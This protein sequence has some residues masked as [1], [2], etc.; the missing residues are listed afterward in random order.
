MCKKPISDGKPLKV[1]QHSNFDNVKTLTFYVHSSMYKSEQALMQE[2]EYFGGTW[3]LFM[4]F[5]FMCF[6]LA[7]FSNNLLQTSIHHHSCAMKAF[8]QNVRAAKI[9]RKFYQKDLWAFEGCCVVSDDILD[10]QSTS[11]HHS[12]KQ[13]LWRQD[14]VFSK[15]HQKTHVGLKCPPYIKIDKTL[16]VD[17]SWHWFYLP[18][19]IV[20]LNRWWGKGIKDNPLR[21]LLHFRVFV[22]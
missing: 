5:S 6:S 16:W 14:V 2:W 13:L 8:R 22:N 18:P 11:Y 3:S 17:T 9:L 10:K 1:A 20:P 21:F 4:C 15:M 12:S 19:E 7:Q